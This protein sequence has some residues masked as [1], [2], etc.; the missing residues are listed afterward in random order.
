MKSLKKIATTLALATTLFT[1]IPAPKANAGLILLPA[2]VGVVILIVGLMQNSLGLVIL[3]GE[4][5]LQNQIESKIGQ[6][7]T[8]ID[9]AQAVKD[10]AAL[11]TEKLANT[12][13]SAENVEI[14][15]TREEILTV[16]AP[17]GL[18]QLESDKVESLISDLN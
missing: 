5:S 8:F 16:L 9:D 18:I 17:T 6:K 11:I 3:D 12:D 7:Y 2:G 14:K 15:L 10:L 13:L 4:Q 1:T